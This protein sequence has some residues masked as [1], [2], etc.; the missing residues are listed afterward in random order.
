M[1]LGICKDGSL[2][3]TLDPMTTLDHINLAGLILHELN[4]DATQEDVIGDRLADY[5]PTESFDVGN[6]GTLK[7]QVRRAHAICKGLTQHTARV[8]YIEYVRD[9]VKLY[10]SSYFAVHLK[11][12]KKSEPMF[13]AINRRGFHMIDWKMVGI[14]DTI[15]MELVQKC[16]FTDKRFFMFVYQKMRE[17]VTQQGKEMFAVY[18]AYCQEIDV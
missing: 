8:K 13:V 5:L 2:Q 6:H 12:G 18:E 16:S 17:F 11:V 1:R 9:K 14:Q 7:E 15:S 4:G 3:V 10:G